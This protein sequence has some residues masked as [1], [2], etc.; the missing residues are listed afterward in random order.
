MIFKKKLKMERVKSATE[1]FVSEKIFQGLKIIYHGSETE[2]KDN[3][4][5]PYPAETILTGVSAYEF[6][7]S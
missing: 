4:G 7:Y 3:M 2:I 6:L 5:L 1:S